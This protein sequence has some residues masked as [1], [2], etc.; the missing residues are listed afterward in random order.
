M[1]FFTWYEWIFL[2]LGIFTQAADII[3]TN[4]AI[5]QG[6]KESIPT[7]RWAMK[8]FGEYWW[9][10]KI[11]IALLV[12]IILLVQPDAWQKYL[13][14]TIWNLLFL[15]AAVSN[16]LLWKKLKARNI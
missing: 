11:L 12:I 10:P 16:Y 7:V 3:T 13:I 8:K 2:A 4:M 1:N 6:G 15:G 9:I 5:A 14:L